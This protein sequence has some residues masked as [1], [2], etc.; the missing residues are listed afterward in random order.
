[1]RRSTF[2]F[3]EYFWPRD[4]LFCNALVTFTANFAKLLFVCLTLPCR[5]RSF[6]NAVCLLLLQSASKKTQAKTHGLSGP[7]RIKTI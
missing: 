6:T 3:A 4:V 5:Y 1:M 2:I 7:L